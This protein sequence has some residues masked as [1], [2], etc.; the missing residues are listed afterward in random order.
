[1]LFVRGPEA[2]L[3]LI[4][5]SLRWG[6]TLVYLGAAV[7]ALRMRRR[8]ANEP[9]KWLA[10]AFGSLGLILISGVFFPKP[11]YGPV[12]LW[13]A[14]ILV[15]VLLCFPY[16]LLRFATSL[17]LRE[18]RVVRAALVGTIAVGVATLALPRFVAQ[19]DPIPGWYRPYAFA[20]VGVWF[21][22]CLAV[23]R[24]LWAAGRGQAPIVRRRLRTMSVGS[25]LIAIVMLGSLMVGSDNQRPTAALLMSRSLGSISGLMFFLAFAAPRWLR[26]L[27]RRSEEPATRDAAATCIRAASVDDLCTALLPRVTEA[28][29]ATGAMLLSAE[30]VVLGSFG[31][32]P[33][34]IERLSKAPDGPDPSVLSAPLDRGRL[35]VA[36]NP[37]APFIG[38][39]EEALLQTLGTFAD[40]A[41]ER[42]SLLERTERMRAEFIAM[43]SHDMRA[44]LA[45]ARGMIET[46]ASEWDHLDNS[47][48]NELLDRA[49]R[50]GVKLGGLI[51][52][53]LEH[54]QL[55]AGS[56]VPSTEE[57]NV[58]RLV[59]DV[60]GNLA[61]L[62]DKHRVVIEADNRLNVVADRQAAER[63]MTNLIV[64]AA[65]YASPGTMITISWRAD[66]SQIA[67]SVAD[68]GIGIA[69]AERAQIFDSFYRGSRTN[70][71]SGLGLGLAIVHRLAELQDGSVS[72]E[73]GDRGSTFT[74]RL[75]AVQASPN[76]VPEP[77]RVAG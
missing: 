56:V 77:E 61:V 57:V 27:W 23:A 26:A 7:A 53:L 13:G 49:S 36:L 9:A 73:S 39:D 51:E 65:K 64:N 67:I 5:E 32:N 30:G 44:P 42:L 75:P 35:V 68:E 17:G 45:A 41:L 4:A 74:V 21:F 29:G 33:S 6:T 38:R 47:L 43:L 55:E 50:N 66:G 60:V 59:D 63:I 19:G 58:A 25:A 10:A 22:V 18:G 24:R 11:P 46:L 70:G 14:K 20:F 48:R 34:S 3:R 76:S 31:L 37:Q 8:S 2:V 71:R 16:F 15:I 62:L 72:V 69:P 1:M 12:A 40:V 28:L 54:S 52:Q